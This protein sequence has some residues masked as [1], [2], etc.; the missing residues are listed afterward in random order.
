[1]S[2]KNEPVGG[3]GVRE[4]SH[5][6]VSHVGRNARRARQ[7]IE[8][9]GVALCLVVLLKTFVIE[10]YRIPSTSMEGTL[11]AGDFL[12]VNKLVY[13][14]TTPRDIPFTDIEIPF[15]RLPCLIPPRRG[16]VVV[17]RAPHTG[18][19]LGAHG[20]PN[21]V[22]RCVALPGDTV[23][24][25]S[26][27]VQVNGIV[28]P[29]PL[30][31]LH[32]IP[33][34]ESVDEERVHAVQQRKG[35]TNGDY[36]PVVLPKVGDEVRLSPQSVLQWRGLIENEGHSV[37]LRPDG[38][39]LVDGRESETYQVER[40]Y[41]FMLGDNRDNSF[42]SRNWGFVPYDAIIGKAIVVYWSSDGSEETSLFLNHWSSVRWERIGRF[43][44]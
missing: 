9:L 39:V 1:M 15:L 32:G 26:N 13:G 17:F 10:A 42:D 28:Y 14:A 36:G 29:L 12:L 35:T 24:I 19:G 6:G 44:R 20:I 3:E 8:L 30:H 31:A 16:D 11:L 38:R 5:A 43:V 18:N 27:T 4:V 37:L 21:Y 40:D 23:V 7:F 33:G 34:R 22:K 25:R 41:F 2:R